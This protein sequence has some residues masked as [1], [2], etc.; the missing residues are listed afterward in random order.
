MV[1]ERSKGQVGDSSSYKSRC[2]SANQ[3][4]PELLRELK[5]MAIR[6][7]LA[8][9]G[10]KS[11][12]MIDRCKS[13]ISKSGT[14]T[15]IGTPDALRVAQKRKWKTAAG[16]FTANHIKFSLTRNPQDLLM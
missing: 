7:S 1:T 10:I 2:D 6:P 8:D 11:G 16:N 12:K 5:K 15:W 9:S 13:C 14:K 3:P 4:S